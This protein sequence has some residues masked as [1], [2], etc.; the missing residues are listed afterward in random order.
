MVAYNAVIIVAP[1]LDTENKVSGVPARVLRYRFT[2][3]QIIKKKYLVN[4]THDLNYI[5]L[6]TL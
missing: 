5:L 4:G 2:T 1:S 3:A 6:W